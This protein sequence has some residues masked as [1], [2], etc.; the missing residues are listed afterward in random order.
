MSVLQPYPVKAPANGAIAST[1]KLGSEIARGALL[2]RIQRP[3]GQAELRSPL[4]GRIRNINK[5]NGSQVLAGDEILNLNSDEGSVYEALRGLALIGQP[6]DIQSIE[7]YA[8]LENASARVRQQAQLT[9]KAIQ[10]RSQGK[11]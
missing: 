5:Q 4:P 1:L 9:V 2:A 10:S 11:R 3:D 6:D 8:A 7:S